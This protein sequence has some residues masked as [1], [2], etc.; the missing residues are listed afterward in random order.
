MKERIEKIF[1][2]VSYRV[3]KL[4]PFEDC[5]LSAMT[6]EAKKR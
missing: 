4:D 2:P 5:I 6:T 3:V 1:H